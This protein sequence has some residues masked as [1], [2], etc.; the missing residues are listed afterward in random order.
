MSNPN[1]AQPKRE[2][3][4]FREEKDRFF[5]T[6]PHSPLTR[7]QKLAFKGLNY[8]PENPDLRIQTTVEEF[9]AIEEI[10]MQTS[11]GDVQNYLRFGRFKFSV[12]GQ[13]AE[14]TI[15]QS[16]DGFFLPFA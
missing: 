15:Y 7:D 9:H 6:G 10:E 8:F 12:D 5:K 13:P 11:T 3:E 2:L 14:L 16:E 4:R 1:Q